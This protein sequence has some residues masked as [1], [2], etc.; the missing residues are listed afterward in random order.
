MIMWAAKLP[1]RQLTGLRLQ[2]ALL[3]RRLHPVDRSFS[4][5]ALPQQH[6]HRLTAGRL[7][8]SVLPQEN[9]CIQK[10]HQFSKIDYFQRQDAGGKPAERNAQEKWQQQSDQRKL[11]LQHIFSV[12]C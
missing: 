8:G 1:E 11:L 12:Q 4:P 9:R 3:R 5:V 2:A 7:S 10:K 6:Q